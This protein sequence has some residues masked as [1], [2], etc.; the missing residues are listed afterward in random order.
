MAY[1]AIPASDPVSSPVVIIFF[2]LFIL[3]AI[4]MGVAYFKRR[5]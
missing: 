4:G 3:A 2:V 1:F 5:K